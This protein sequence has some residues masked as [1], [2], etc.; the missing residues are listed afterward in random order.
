MNEDKITLMKKDLTELP[1]KRAK[2]VYWA[3]IFVRQP[4]F[5]LPMDCCLYFYLLINTH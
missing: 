5:K 3:S 4:N 2:N 1:Q